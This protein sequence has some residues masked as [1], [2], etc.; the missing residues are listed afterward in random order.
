MTDEQLDEVFWLFD[1]GGIPRLKS[2]QGEVVLPEFSLHRAGR[3]LSSAG[4]CSGQT[5]I[6]MRSRQ[7]LNDEYADYLGSCSIQ[8][9]SLTYS[10]HQPL[11]PKDVYPI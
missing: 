7:I 4:F 11:D 8:K 10:S 5:D 1:A 2:E 6:R 3:V 9:G